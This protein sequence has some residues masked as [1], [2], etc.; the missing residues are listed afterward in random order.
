MRTPFLLVLILLPL[1]A[2]ALV[3]PRFSKA[4]NAGGWVLF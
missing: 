1:S 4:G 3:Y 2:S